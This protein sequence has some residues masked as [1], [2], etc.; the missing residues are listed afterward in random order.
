MAAMAARSI[1]K[2]SISFGL[3]N[4]PIQV[5]S[6]T[7]REDYTS[8]SQLCDKGHK[9]RYKKWCPV[10]ER[11]VQWSEIKKGHE[12]TKNNFLVIEKEDLD[13]IKLK[14]NNTIEVKEFIEA[15]EFDPIFIEKNYYVGPDPGKKKTEAATRAYSLLVKILHETGKI[16]IGKVVLREREHLVA[17]RAYQR[18]LVMHQL[19]YLD[20]IRPMDE[21]GNLDSLQKVDSKELSLGKTL[22]ENLTTEK[23]DPGQYSDTYAK[24][25]EKLIEAKSKGQEVIPKQVEEEP[26]ETTD[27]IEAL[28]ASLKVKPKSSA[29]AKGKMGIAVSK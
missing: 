2:G 23:F 5:F 3:V 26:E 8:F 4:I 11:E 10:E 24:E 15:D 20:E 22:V 25:L 12:I 9:I 19:K 18:G 21:I 29:K 13:N 6:S 14:T 1:W 7:Q 17:L 28:K 16:A 27:I